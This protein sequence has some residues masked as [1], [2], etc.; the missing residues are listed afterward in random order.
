M[1]G[2]SSAPAPDPRMGQAALKQI[3]LAERQFADYQNNDRPWMR[4]IANQALGLSRDSAS[5]ARD[6]FGFSRDVANRQLGIADEQLGLTRSQVQRA[7]ALSDYQLELMKYNDDRYRN[8]AVPFEDQLLRDVNRFDSDA[9]KTGLITQAQ[10]DVGSAFDRAEQ[11]NFR[12]QMRRGVNPNSG[13]AAAMANQNSI[14]KATAMASA[15]NKTRQAADQVGL[16]TKMQMYGGMKGLAGLGATN[17]GLATGAM[18]AGTGAIGTG[19]S[20][21]NAGVG[22]MGIGNSALGIMQAGGSG[23][24]GAAG[25]YLNANNAALS[26]FNSGM[27]AGISG[28][29]QYTQLGQN[30]AKINNDADPF[31]ALLGAGAQLGAAYIGKSDRRFKTDIVLLGT[32]ERTGLDLYEFRYLDS[33]QRYRGVMADEVQAKYPQA[34]VVL[35]GGYLAVNYTMLGLEMTAVE[36]EFA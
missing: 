5:L 8:V 17:A 18:G 15:A 7:N 30:A 12:T 16:S 23:M 27:S 4:D 20:A 26:G 21:L 3:E 6:Q 31:A 11:E 10:A 1:G 24:M 34:V 28:L 2:K 25:G 19:M 14:A 36:G 35:P 13:A 9:Y 29:G 32:D 33:P 22:A